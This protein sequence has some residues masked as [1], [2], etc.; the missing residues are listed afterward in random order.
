MATDESRASVTAIALRA[1]AIARENRHDSATLEHMLCALL[2]REEVQK[3]LSDLSVDTPQII[4]L[5]MGFMSGGF[6]TETDEAP[7]KTREFEAVCMRTIGSAMFGPRKTPDGLDMLVQMTAMPHEDSFA[8]TG[9]L[10]CGL[11]PLMLKRYLSHGP[12]AAK[13]SP[14]SPRMPEGVEG[15]SVPDA[16]PTSVE[17][18]TRLVLKYCGDLNLAARESKIDPLIGRESEVAELI[19]TT[20]RR[21]K[22]NVVLVGEPG[23]GKTAI[24]EGLAHQIVHGRVPEVLANSTVYSLD[25]GALVAGTRFRGDFE[26]RMKHLLKAL[27][28]IEGAILFID[29]IHTI[30]DAG[31]GSKGSLDVANLLKPAL[32]K[33]KLRCI[34]S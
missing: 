19:K 17:E 9:L 33:G 4:T 16:D 10:R 28:M 2:E 25:I 29:E 12:N 32:A 27:G 6:I 11:T 23:V 1:I 20:A 3:A 30:M 21:T 5:M 26:E 13:A 14:Q 7:I 31:A 24:A 34:G 8:L 18:A 15:A 22:N